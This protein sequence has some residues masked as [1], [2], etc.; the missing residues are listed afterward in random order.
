L[1]TQGR[2]GTDL[3]FPGRDLGAGTVLPSTGLRRGDVYFH[4]GWAVLLGY[5][6]AAWRALEKGYAANK[7]AIDAQSATGRPAGLRMTA[8]DTGWEWEWTGTFWKLRNPGLAGCSVYMNADRAVSASWQTVICQAK[9]YDPLNCYDTT[10]G[11][12]TAPFAGLYRLNG[13][14]AFVTNS[15]GTARGAIFRRV[16]DGSYI[17]ASAQVALPTTISTVVNAAAI[18]MPLTAGQQII[19]S[20]YSSVSVS[21]QGAVTGQQSGMAIELVDQT[22]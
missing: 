18:I 14:V 16:A 9:R 4:T 2:L 1:E 3:G 20:G 12:Y 13:T 8:Q 15:A 22:G 5:N 21:H 11:Y 17:E 10:T 6:G 19:L 7:A